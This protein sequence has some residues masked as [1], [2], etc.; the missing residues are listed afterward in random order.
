LAGVERMRTLTGR[1]DPR[2]LA[3]G[4]GRLT[5]AL[6]ITREH[7]GTDLVAGNELII[8]RGDPVPRERVRVDT[9][10]GLTVAREQPWRFFEAVSPFVSRGRTKGRPVRTAS[11]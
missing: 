5:Q 10:I 6:A 1:Q 7:N 8:E 11:E 4:P 2:L 3:A 9:R